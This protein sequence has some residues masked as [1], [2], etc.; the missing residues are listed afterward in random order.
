M[1]RFGSTLARWTRV[2]ARA[3]AP[4]DRRRRRWPSYLALALVALTLLVDLFGSFGIDD[5]ADTATEHAAGIL[6]GPFYGGADRVGQD[7]I[8]I[9]LISDES[10]QRFRES[11]WPMSYQR[12]GQIVDS[13]AVT[14][15]KAI[16]LDFYFQ[17][18]QL[19][20]E[21]AG[22]VNEAGMAFMRRRILA[23][24]RSGIP[25][26]V[27][28][29]GE[30]DGLR[31]LRDLPQLGVV[32]RDPRP[33]A[34]TS[35]DPEGREMAAIGLYR[36]W[37][38]EHPRRGGLSP[39]LGQTLA[40]DWG[41]GASGWMSHRMPREDAR[42]C[43]GGDAGERAASL[44]RLFTRFGAPALFKETREQIYF[45]CPYFDTVPAEWLSTADPEL[46]QDLRERL[47]GKIVLVGVDIGYL[48]D[49]VST[50]LLGRVPG[51]VSHAMALDNLME[52]GPGA[53][54]YPRQVLFGWDQG[55]ILE[56]V[57][58]AL[59]VVLILQL[60]RRYGLRDDEALGFRMQLLVW[61]LI[62][63][64]GVGI[65]CLL[66]WPMFKLLGAVPVGLAALAITEDLRTI[67]V[68]GGD[69]SGEKSG[70]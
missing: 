40:L 48:S 41:F 16:F 4:A 42:R 24:G 13:I 31:P 66:W 56:L 27:G 38:A 22:E 70:A 67:G 37:A 21:A 46:R 32:S 39:V 12:V 2:S 14:Q 19:L 63:V 15:P 25:T 49:K 9:V 47:K 43:R 57:L 51:V 33:F 5:R 35:H 62:A 59:G 23:A 29:V 1:K 50:P 52:A 18:P 60:R 30:A 11:A 61:G 34:Y 6:S 55:D 53:S 3:S 26:F 28:P 10:M 45:A 17:R 36:V 7:N 64:L 54:R 68:V 20:D 8:V 58:I 44:T 69:R 65:A